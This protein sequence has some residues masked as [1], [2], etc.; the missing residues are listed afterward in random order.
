MGEAK[1]AAVWVFGGGI[2]ESVPPVLVD[3]DETVPKR[4]LTRRGNRSKVATRTSV[5][6]L[7][8][9]TGTG[10]EDLRPLPV[11]QEVRAFQFDPAN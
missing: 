2:D 6:V 11:P 7:R 9:R 4:A 5:A 8:G 3:E 1:A 10:C